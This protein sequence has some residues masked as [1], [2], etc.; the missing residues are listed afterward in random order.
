VAGIRGEGVLASCEPDLIVSRELRL[1]GVRGVATGSHEQALRLLAGGRFPFG[2]LSR[3]VAGF[4]GLSR[5]LLTMAGETG[6]PPPM[7]AVFTPGEP[8]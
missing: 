8:A 7:H 6:D 2:S 4:D 5:L 1:I 3:A